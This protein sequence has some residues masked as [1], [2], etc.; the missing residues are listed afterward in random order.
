LQALAKFSALAA[1]PFVF[2]LGRATDARKNFVRMV[3]AFAALP[4]PVKISLP[5]SGVYQRQSK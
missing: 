4:A 5:I 3:K 2:C 1:T